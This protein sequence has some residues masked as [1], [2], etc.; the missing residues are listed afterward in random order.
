VLLSS[1]R[2]ALGALALL[3]AILGGIAVAPTPTAAVAA[4]LL[5]SEYVEGSSFN[6]ALEIENKTGA[7][8]PPSRRARPS[9]SL[10]PAPSPWARSS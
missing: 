2:R 7:P 3:L 6:K 10:S 9:A 4:D 5:I 1:R 8:A